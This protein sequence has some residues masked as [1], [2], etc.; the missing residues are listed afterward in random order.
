MKVE[1][2]KVVGNQ[3][4]GFFAAIRTVFFGRSNFLFDIAARFVHGFGE[5]PN[6]FVRPLDAVKR[7]FGL[8][9]H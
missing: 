6:V 8:I 5:H 1:F 3:E 7:R 2:R 9:T 4:E